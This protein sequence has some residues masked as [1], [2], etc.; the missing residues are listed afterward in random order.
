LILDTRDL[1]IQTVESSQDGS[2]FGTTWTRDPILGSPLTIEVGA[3]SKV[4]RIRYHTSP[5]ASGLQWL[6]PAQTVLDLD[7]ARSRLGDVGQRLYTQVLQRLE[8]ARDG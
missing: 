7:L 2:A 6:E 4:V 8:R 5:Q 1:T 3:A